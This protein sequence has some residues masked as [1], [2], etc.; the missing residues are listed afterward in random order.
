MLA[1]PALPA[2]AGFFPA[3][4]AAAGVPALATRRSTRDARAPWSRNHLTF[5]GTRILTAA[6]L[7]WSGMILGAFG[8][9]VVPAAHDLGRAQDDA[10]L[11]ALLG[12]VSPWLTALGVANVIAAYGAL[13]ERR[14]WVG[15]AT[16]LIAAGAL[17][18]A[19][20]TVLALAGRDPFL[21]TDRAVSPT[22][23]GIGNLAWTLWLQ[24]IVAWGV[25]RVAVARELV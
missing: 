3:Q 10:G 9:L 20:G 6:A 2:R 13:R 7:F 22:G 8:A 19:A 1:T 5:R 23:Q 21:L 25:R 24:G 11:M 4:R 16:W 12:T 14:W 17:V 15:L 18:I